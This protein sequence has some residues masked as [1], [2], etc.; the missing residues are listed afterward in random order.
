MIYCLMDAK[1]WESKQHQS[2]VAIPGPE[3]FVH[4]CDTG[5]MAFV[6]RNHFPSGLSVVALGVDPV[7][8][9]AETRYEPGSGGEPERFPH[10]YGPI[11]REDVAEVTVL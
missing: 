1:E 7:V 8:L 2:I 4:C 3:G 11:R 9:D 10:V 6:R 5:Q